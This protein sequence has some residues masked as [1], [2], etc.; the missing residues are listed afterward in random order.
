MGSTVAFTSR[1][2]CG[3]R[4]A[5]ERLLFFNACQDRFAKQIV[6]AI[7]RFGPPEIVADGDCLRVRV[8]GL[9]D[10]QSLFAVDTD[11]GRP[12]AV[13][14]YV[15]ADLEHITVLHV[16]MSEEYCAGGSLEGSN[17]LLRLLK[18]IRRS[19]RR[20]KGVRRVEVL[21]G[22]PRMRALA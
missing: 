3:Q 22:A 15:R 19:T 9:P 12:V 18:E 1:L 4:E 6:D 10:V 8:G 17:L 20:V 16:G 2:A 13:A 14:V 11:S 7:D 21:Y 5:L